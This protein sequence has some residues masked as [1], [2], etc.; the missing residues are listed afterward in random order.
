MLLLPDDE[1][2]S[3]AGGSLTIFLKPMPPQSFA[4]FFLIFY[5]VLYSFSSNWLDFGHELYLQR[6]NKM[7]FYLAPQLSSYGRRLSWKS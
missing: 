5:N 6:Q 2:V 1:D 3:L 4:I 7:P